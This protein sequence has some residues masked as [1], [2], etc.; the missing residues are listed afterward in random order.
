MSDRFRP[1]TP[2]SVS[3]AQITWPKAKL[4]RPKK[5]PKQPVLGSQVQVATLNARRAPARPTGPR[6]YGLSKAPIVLGG[7]G[8]PPN[9]FLTVH[10]TAVEWVAYFWLWDV[11]GV[12]GDP[13]DPPFVG[14]PDFRFAYQK[15]FPGLGGGK[16]GSTSIDFLVRQGPRGDLAVRIQSEAF[17]VFAKSDQIVYDRFQKGRIARTEDIIDVFEQYLMTDAQRRG[18]SA[19]RVIEDAVHRIEWADPTLTGGAFRVR[20]RG[21]A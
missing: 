9:G 13:R 21:G 2:Q 8:T 15:V 7:P 3:V 18:G 10:T 12:E 6:M 14:A 1:I 20:V 19:H 4:P 16:T 11:L 17:H 5:P